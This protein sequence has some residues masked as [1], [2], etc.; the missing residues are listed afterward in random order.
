MKRKKCVFWGRIY[1]PRD[2]YS[3]I[4]P[5][6]GPVVRL[7]IPTPLNKIYRFITTLLHSTSYFLFSRQ[8]NVYGTEFICYKPD[9]LS[10]FILSDVLLDSVISFEN[11]SADIFN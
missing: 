6:P 1:V 5:Y 4:F 8:A 11:K 2:I 7:Q 9:L 10:G 3:I